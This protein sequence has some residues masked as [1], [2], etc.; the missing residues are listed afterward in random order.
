MLLRRPTSAIILLLNILTF[1]SGAVAAPISPALA[2][3]KAPASRRPAKHVAGRTASVRRLQP[4]RV[5]AIS[6][7]ARPTRPVLV[8][9]SVRGANGL[10]LPGATVWVAGARQLIAVANESGD[11]TLLLPSAAAVSLTFG[12]TGAGQETTTLAAPSAKQ[13]LV[14]A[15]PT[16][17]VFQP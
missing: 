4:V 16:T 11:F 17:A 12:Y 5:L 3:R 10:P 1:I 15:L 8:S 2:A 6:N 9:G 13:F 7:V 14:L